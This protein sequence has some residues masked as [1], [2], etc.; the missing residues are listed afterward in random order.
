MTGFEP[1]T[2]CSRSQKRT[3]LTIWADTMGP[4][5]EAE[6]IASSMPAT[7]AL[8]REASYVLQGEQHRQRRG[9][10]K[11]DSALRVTHYIKR[12]NI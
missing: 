7:A 3:F 2:P 6:K 11:Q 8:A 10:G 5:S 9:K 1:A 12:T 4:K